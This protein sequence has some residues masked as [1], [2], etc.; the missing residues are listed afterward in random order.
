MNLRESPMKENSTA[1]AIDPELQP[2][3]A[4]HALAGLDALLTL[5]QPD[6]MLSARDIG[7]MVHLI[8]QAQDESRENEA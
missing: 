4:R 3:L 2:I 6:E 5:C 1:A 8:S 7:A